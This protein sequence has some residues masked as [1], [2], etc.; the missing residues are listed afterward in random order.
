MKNKWINHKEDSF[1]GRLKVYLRLIHLHE[2][3]YDIEDK[4]DR[5]W[6]SVFMKTLV[7][8]ARVFK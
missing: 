3:I 1:S 5:F 6:N 4:E 8:E 7:L 2:H